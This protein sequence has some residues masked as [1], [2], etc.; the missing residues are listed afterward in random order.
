MRVLAAALL[1]ALGASAARAADLSAVDALYWHRYDDK[2]LDE[3]VAK[4][5]ELLQASPKD[6]EAMWRLG[7]AIMR[8]GEKQKKK[9][10][11][12]ADYLK[13]E[14]LLKQAVVLAP[15]SVDAHF[16]YGVTMGRRGEAQG[17]LKSLFLVK[18]IRL[19]MNEVVRL[20]PKHGGAHRVL[21]E[22]L[23]QVPG[24]AG[25]DKK[26][27]LE[28]FETAIRLSPGFTANYQPLAEAYQHYDRKDDAVKTLKACVDVKDPSD[29]AA[30]P[31]DQADCK[32]LLDKLSR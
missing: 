26:K 25:G 10:D 9:A 5:D 13:A 23:W 11:K 31:E 22:I 15:D 16:F 32:K 19:Q 30:A 1:L 17:V 20:D 27:A 29:P 3:C 2:K 18:P 21:A 7:R 12:L 24:F 4:L 6:P 8:R 14:D 28:E